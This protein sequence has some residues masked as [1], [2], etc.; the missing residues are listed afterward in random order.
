VYTFVPGADTNNG[1]TVTSPVLSVS[2]IFERYDLDQSD[3][4][5]IDTGHYLVESNIV[6]NSGDSGVATN[7]VRIIGSTNL[8]AGGTT[9]TRRHDPTIASL[10]GVSG[11]SGSTR[12]TLSLASDDGRTRRAAALASSAPRS[13]NSILVKFREGASSSSAR[14]SV[15]TAKASQVIRTFDVL[16]TDVVEI[17]KGQTV[18][19]TIAAYEANPDVE[20]AEPNYIYRLSNVPDDPSFSA[21][22]GLHNT[23]QSGGT[24]GADIGALEA[25]EI[26]TGSSNVIVA[27]IDSGVDYNHPDL[28]ANM[29]VNP[30]PTFGDTYGASYTG[31]FG[32]VSSGNPM[33]VNGHG[34]HVAGTIGAVGSN[35]VG[36]VGVNWNVRIMALRFTDSDGYGSTADAISCIEYAVRN[37]AK[38][39]NNSWGGGGYSSALEDAIYNAGLSNV[40]FVAAAGN[41]GTNNDSDPH[42]PSNYALS[43]VIAVASS[44]RTDALSSFSNYGSNS[45]H[46]AAP[47]SAIY[48][49]MWDDTYANSDGTSMA[50]PH[51][52]GVAALLLAHYPAATYTHLRDWILTGVDLLPALSG[53]VQSGGRLSAAAAFAYADTGEP[54]QPPS[55]FNPVNPEAVFQ[56]S[57]ARNLE[58]AWLNFEEAN[59]G[60]YANN[61]TS[62]AG[63]Q[64]LFRDLNFAGG[65]A[66]I[67]L[68]G[69]GTNQFSRISARGMNGYGIWA[70]NSPGNVVDSSVFWSNRL[71]SVS[72]TGNGSVAISNSSLHAFG[73]VTNAAVILGTGQVRGDYNNYFIEDEASYFIVNNEPFGGL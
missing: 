26:T 57:G 12:S 54:P 64:H 51:V 39:L 4:I 2:T 73:N 10:G 27:V 49:T 17:P 19:E 20:Y 32:S 38:I 5:F 22:W 40:L 72:F 67:R 50:T 15:H 59:V 61:G 29:W 66:G 62:V 21:L 55:N 60:I 33:D 41:D 25:W 18:T 30:S 69:S 11:S 28:A 9:F 13:P 14:R 43:N 52:A 3:T 6:V 65:Y 71:G 16:R 70:V 35:G 56:L 37:G 7:R 47:G 46:I 36:V 44:D 8:L 58:F 68:A 1:I 45:V 31:G 24:V 42:Y 23:G 63:D 48:S 34:T 53:V